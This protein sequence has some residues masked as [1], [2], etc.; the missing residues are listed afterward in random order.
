M[1]RT[2]LL[3]AASSLTATEASAQSL[4]QQVQPERLGER[5]RTVSLEPTDG[6]P[7]QIG[8]AHV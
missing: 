3:I 7:G 5:G 1:I 4:F 8:R 2:T 6:A